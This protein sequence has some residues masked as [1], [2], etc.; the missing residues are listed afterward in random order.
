ML[1]SFKPPAVTVYCGILFLAL[2]VGTELTQAET[3]VPAKLVVGVMD[4]PP[5]TSKAASGE[6]EG[7]S[8]E[9][10]Q[11]VAR[12]LNTE[13]ELREYH[14][15][16]LLEAAVAS[17]AVD[18]TPVAAVTAELEPLADFSNP[19]YRS[20]AALAVKTANS[21]NRLQR[22][23]EQLFSM[24]ALMTIVSLGLLWLSAGTVVWLFEKRSNPEMFHNR[25]LQGLGQGVW[26][27]AVTM[28]TVGYGDKAPRT[29]GGRL[30]AIVW[31]LAS[32]ILISSFTATMATILTVDELGGKVRSVHDLPNV[33]V[34]TLMHSE[35][36]EELAR[37]GV[38]GVPFKSTPEG[39]QALVANRIDVFVYDEALVK[40]FIKA[41]YS[42][43]LRI[44]SDSF[45]YYYLAMA[46]P[47]GSVLR[48]PLNRALLAVLAEADWRERLEQ[49][50]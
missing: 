1:S 38:A 30:V 18:L 13:I 7:L 24:P 5:F 49:S 10:L 4:F 29:V 15:A 45:R 16:D 50:L 39:L 35:Y 6:W 43:T 46:L 23:F 22:L 41:R 44:L 2:C 25:F 34:G 27:A 31:M 26:W 48:E 9:L 14:R 21:G 32:I 37:Q 36:L 33:R 42:G 40:H 3:G 20:G 12:E 17:G 11:A 19:F 28:T 47:P 8:I